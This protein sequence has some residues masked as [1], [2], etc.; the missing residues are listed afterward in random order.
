MKRAKGNE[1]H[2]GLNIPPGVEYWLSSNQ[3]GPIKWR[4]EI[5]CSR[6]IP[7]SEIHRSAVVRAEAS[8]C[9][10]QADKQGVTDTTRQMGMGTSPEQAYV[11]KSC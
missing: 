7:R 6:T 11:R 9:T 2:Q 3:T 10:W 8:Q 5:H 1:D 4:S